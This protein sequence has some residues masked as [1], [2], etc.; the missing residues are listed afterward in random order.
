ML[1]PGIEPGAAAWKAAMLPLHHESYTI[2]GN[3]TRVFRVTGG[4][5]EPLYYDGFVSC[6][7]RTHEVLNI[8]PWIE[9]LW[10]LGKAD[11]SCFFFLFITSFDHLDILITEKWDSNPRSIMRLNLS[12]KTELLWETLLFIWYFPYGELNPGLRRERA[13]S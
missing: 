13:P 8:R 1:S 3:W 9:P 12:Q 11:L 4:Y 7:I 6:G 10:P 5:T 2:A